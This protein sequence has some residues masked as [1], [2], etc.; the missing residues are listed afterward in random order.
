MKEKTKLQ[1]LLTERGSVLKKYK[2]LAIGSGGFFSLAKYEIITTFL[3]GLPGS[4]GYISRRVF[5]RTLFKNI[6]KGVI[7]GKG[8]T[9]RHASKI[10]LGNNVV[11]DDYCVLDAKGEKKNNEIIISDNVIV[12]RNTILSCKGGKI[13]I[14]KN[15]NI[16]ANCLIHSENSVKLGK[17]ILIAAFCYL[18]GGGNYG[19]TRKDIP[20]ISQP[21]LSSD[22]IVIKDNVWLGARVTVLDGVTVGRDTIVGASAL[23][24]KNLPEFVIAVG[25]PAHVLKKR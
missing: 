7:L 2:V 5:Y 10:S 1:T 9:I 15:T 20:V 21:S 18:V 16:G 13:E 3:S 25:A 24:T 6:G 4:L 23:V 14:G 17:N 22:G 8:L 11:I 19:F 12:S